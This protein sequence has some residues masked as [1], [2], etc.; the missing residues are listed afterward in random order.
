V[1]KQA[2]FDGFHS[3]AD[4]LPD[5][6]PAWPDGQGLPRRTHRQARC[7]IYAPSCGGV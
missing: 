4:G 7:D 3:V 6:S 5:R 2:F 1:E